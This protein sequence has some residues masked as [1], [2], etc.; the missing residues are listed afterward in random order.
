MNVISVLALTFFYVFL[1][2]KLELLG[3]VE[4]ILEFSSVISFSNHLALVKGMKPSISS[5]CKLD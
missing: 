5:P 1:R 4:N 3:T 2:N